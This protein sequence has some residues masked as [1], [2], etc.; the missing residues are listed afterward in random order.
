LSLCQIGPQAEDRH[1]PCVPVRQ[2]V[3]P[4]DLVEHGVARRIPALAGRI[5]GVARRG[6][7]RREH[8]LAVQE[9]DE[10]GV[11]LVGV[12]LGEQSRLA[13]RLEPIDRCAQHALRLGIEL[14]AVVDR[15]I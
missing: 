14:R 10:V 3:E 13:F 11:P 9:F 15:G 6:Q 1:L 5:V 4:E 12:A 7:Q 2:S 8:S